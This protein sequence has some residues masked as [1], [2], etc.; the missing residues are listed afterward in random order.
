M[1]EYIE[2]EKKERRSSSK[3]RLSKYS[4]PKKELMPDLVAPTRKL[5]ELDGFMGLIMRLQMDLKNK[6]TA[7]ED[8]LMTDPFDETSSV[9]KVRK[10]I[11]SY[12]FEGQ[13]YPPEIADKFSSEKNLELELPRIPRVLFLP[14]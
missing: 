13:V 2:D 5:Q 12:T 7:F 14:S 3:R 10:T 11:Q 8:V 6:V 1:D 4:K 9:A